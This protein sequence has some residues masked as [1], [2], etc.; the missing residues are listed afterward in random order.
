MGF[1]ATFTLA[2]S[3]GI[4]FQCRPIEGTIPL[5]FFSFEKAANILVGDWNNIPAV[6]GNQ[7]PGI[8]AS[9]IVNILAD[10]L[11]LIFVIPRIRKDYHKVSSHYTKTQQ[12]SYK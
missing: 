5:L 1:I 9:G 7:D 11:L 8:I 2:L 6:C 4:I 10:I 3:L 12:S